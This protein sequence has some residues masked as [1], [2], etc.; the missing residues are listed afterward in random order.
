[1][2]SALILA[3]V[4]ASLAAQA[5]PRPLL[6]AEDGAWCWFGNP[7]ALWSDGVLY[8]GYVRNA[9][10]RV[11][12]NAYQPETGSNTVLWAS[13][14]RER[15][16]HDNPGLLE[17]GDG[18]LLAIYAKHNN[19]RRFY[20]RL[21]SNAKRTNWG[22]ELVFA[23]TTAGV[24]YAN[25]YQLAGESGR[26]FNFMRN[27]N[28]NPTFTTSDSSATNWSAPRI[29]IRTGSGGA[30]PYVQYCSDYTH[31]IDLVYTDGHP[32]GVV[33]NSLYHAF[34]REGA[35]YRS[36]GS[37]LKYLT[38]APLLHDAGERGSVIYQYSTAVA[39]EADQH[40]PGGRA[41]CWDVAYDSQ[42]APATVFSVQRTNVM[43]TNWYDDRIYYYY[44]RWTGSTWQKRFIA[45]AGRPLY[46]SERD[47]AGGIS[48]DPNNANVVYLSSNA[49][50][51][52]NL[53][54]TRK[55]KLRAGDRY[56]IFHGV[57]SDGGLTFKWQAVTANSTV[58]NLRPYVPR[59]RSSYANGLI[60][61][62]GAYHSYTSWNTAVYG[63]FSNAAVLK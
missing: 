20:Y 7:R 32:S 40:I 4:L 24:T 21:S 18:R 23:N 43:G 26:V 2:A 8:F 38:N 27:L 55:I 58:D 48:L 57:T 51:P 12:L 35:I 30:R 61:F 52:F 47:Y 45:H 19:E 13:E 41:W 33:A 22:P 1:M 17:L 42:G 15:D 60:W 46:S 49:A 10:R 36:D 5:Q 9:D 50:E 59:G 39:R 37:L 62:A 63:L 3:G 44:A 29:L 28:F 25:P 56:E 34:Y 6:L 54:D 16:D 31:R 11:A 14:M 53:S